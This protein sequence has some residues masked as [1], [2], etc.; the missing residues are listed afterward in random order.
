MQE[1]DSHDVEYDVDVHGAQDETAPRGREMNNIDN[2]R[3]QQNNRN[4]QQAVAYNKAVLAQPMR[5]GAIQSPYNYPG[6]RPNYPNHDMVNHNGQYF[7]QQQQQHPQQYY[8]RG[9]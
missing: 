5:A 1:Q 2:Y 4:Q 9:L 8:R 6:I 7:I 3:Y